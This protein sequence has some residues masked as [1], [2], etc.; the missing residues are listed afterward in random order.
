MSP[1]F[2]LL[3]M[4]YAEGLS[5]I[6]SLRKLYSSILFVASFKKSL[7]FRGSLV[8]PET[9]VC[10]PILDSSHLLDTTRNIYSDPRY[11]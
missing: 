7:Q 6:I 3:C 10:N 1:A 9:L 2:L 4:N 8:C 11:R 5:F